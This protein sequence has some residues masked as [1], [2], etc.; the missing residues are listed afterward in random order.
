[1]I[2]SN[3][4]FAVRFSNM[5][6]YW[7]V[8]SVHISLTNRSNWQTV[9]LSDLCKIR[10][11]V[12]PLQ[13]LESRQ[14]KFLD[15]ISFDEGRVFFGNRTQTKMTQYRAKPGDIAVSKIN[16]RKRAIG[17][18]PNE[19]EVGL[20]IHFRALI[21]ENKKV[22][23]QYLWLAL[24]S[25]YCQNQFDVETGGIGKG[26]I[27]EER[28]LDIRV[29]LPPLDV[30]HAIVS[31]WQDGQNRI[32]EAKDSLKNVTND[33][34]E[35]LYSHYYQNTKIDVMKSRIMVVN[36]A[37]LDGWDMKSARAS[38]FRSANQ[39]FHPLSEFAEEA[40]ESV[41]TYD[42]PEKDWAV[43]GVNNKEGVFF[44]YNQQG[45]EFNTAYK[46]IYKDWFFHNPT[47]SSVGSLGIVPEVP[48]NAVTSPEYQ[49]WKI[50]QGLIPGYVA[51]LIGTPFFISLIQFHRV[52]AVKQRLYVENLLKIRV[53]VIPE[54]EQQ[55][56]A[57]ARE[58]ALAQV[59]KSREMAK[60]IETEVEA[61]ILGTKKI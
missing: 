2:T 16:A 17:I 21:P 53:P 55:K 12:V 15:R 50:K 51:A 37:E 8:R 11:E 57:D 52:G 10:F 22:N 33:L 42:E 43:Y 25:K 39:N 13:E 26:E 38:A 34:N 54:H 24:R 14:V 28:L 59:A 58:K 30:Q 18:I 4:G 44:S 6:N 31:R 1:M 61:L 19:I 56:I 46:K 60:E 3:C 36:W 41:R 29:P 49:V 35:W 45:K 7:E 47:R 40:T 32:N 27:S 5:G 48:E 20:T 23:T 9:L